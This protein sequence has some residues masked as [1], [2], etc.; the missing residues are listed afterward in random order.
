VLPLTRASDKIY[1]PLG[2]ELNQKWLKLRKLMLD[3][4]PNNLNIYGD[5]SMSKLVTQRVH[6]REWN[7]WET[8]VS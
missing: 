7:G 5:V 6:P 2:E 4:I 8:I 3:Y 1:G